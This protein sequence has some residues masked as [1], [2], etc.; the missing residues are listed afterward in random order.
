MKSM[1]AAISSF[2]AMG[3]GS[4]QIG[5]KM[6]RLN[7]PKIKSSLSGFGDTIKVGDIFNWELKY[8]SPPY[9]SFKSDEPLCLDA[10]SDGEDPWMRYIS[11]SGHIGSMNW[12]GGGWERKFVLADK[13]TTDRMNLALK[14]RGLFFRLY[15]TYK[16][17]P[18]RPTLIPAS[19]IVW[20]GNFR[21]GIREYQT[22][23]GKMNARHMKITKVITNRMF[24]SFRMDSK[25]SIP[26]DFPVEIN[27]EIR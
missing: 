19:Y 11:P 17:V 13:E 8:T 21:K 5:T 15:F 23:Y 20:V 9:S 27:Y 4:I 22:P 3:V 24:T 14:Y 26:E 16:Q 12:R 6:H 7:D 25:V 1:V 18:A 2:G 10:V